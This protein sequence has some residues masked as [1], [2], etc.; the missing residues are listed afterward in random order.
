M[1][2][3]NA[4]VRETLTSRVLLNDKYEGK[5]VVMWDDTH[6]NLQFKPSSVDAQRTTYSAYYG[7]MYVKEVYS[8]SCL[9]VLV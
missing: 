5:R 8:F 3:I 4:R 2:I 9:V 1:E 6:I 7:V